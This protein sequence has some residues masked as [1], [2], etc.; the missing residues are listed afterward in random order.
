MP[1]LL[2]LRVNSVTF[3]LR[4][5]IPQFAPGVPPEDGIVYANVKATALQPTAVTPLPAWELEPGQ[6]LLIPAT[7]ME[8]GD[9]DIV[10]KSSSGPPRLR[11]T[12]VRVV[13]EDDRTAVYRWRTGSSL[14]IHTFEIESPEIIRVQLEVVSSKAGYRTDHTELRRELENTAR[15]LTLLTIAPSEIDAGTARSIG[16]ER[17]DWWPLF[18]SIVDE[19][20][21][22]GRSI[23]T[24][25]RH[26]LVAETNRRPLDQVRRVP[27]RDLISAFRSE[28]RWAPSAQHPLTMTYGTGGCIGPTTLDVTKR[29][30]SFDIPENRL[31]VGITKQVLLKLRELR[32]ALPEAVDPAVTTGP[33]RRRL[34]DALSQL[35]KWETA[36]STLWNGSPL[37]EVP[38]D[39]SLTLSQG[40]AHD[41]RYR[42]LVSLGGRLRNAITLSGEPLRVGLKDTWILYEYWCFLTLVKLLSTRLTLK[43]FD[44]LAFSPRRTI[45][46][47]QKGERSS[48]VFQSSSGEEVTV[49]YNLWFLEG[50][51][52]PQQPDNVIGVFPGSTSSAPLYVLDAKYRLAYD[53]DYLDRYGAPGP[54][55]DAINQ[56][57]RYRDAIVSPRNGNGYERLVSTAVVIFPS[58]DPEQF[59]EHRFFK[60]LS[61][62]GVGAIPALPGNIAVLEEF[63]AAIAT[64]FEGA[65]NGA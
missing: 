11:R 39:P 1:E 38:P 3:S 46:R 55:A 36:L 20:H 25:P 63:V 42:R 8:D 29:S 60:S 65:A 6:P 32:S 34:D 18:K 61:T 4:G 23:A 22:F 7:A 43:S 31:V 44:G 27:E 14:G 30:A 56:M 51:T 17:L 58:S 37:A 53:T 24:Q 45:L 52:T 64:K 26:G 16:N 5:A 41:G 21:R 13:L 19:F 47:L 48:A 10:L 9:Y 57:H 62:I 50:P 12:N 35:T 49:V 54:P 40:A 33:A 15:A 28:A 2:E 59:R